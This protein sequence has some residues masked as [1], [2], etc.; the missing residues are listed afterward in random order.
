MTAFENYFSKTELPPSEIHL[1]SNIPKSFQLEHEALSKGLSVLNL[2]VDQHL[3]GYPKTRATVG[4][5][6]SRNIF[7]SFGQLAYFKS[8][9]SALCSSE[10]S[11]LRSPS[12]PASRRSYNLENS[13][14][15]PLLGGLSKLG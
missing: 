1:S 7:F 12:E 8:E 15:P 13:Y 4:K 5:L 6:V 14:L 9:L 2:L 11:E 3:A 10:C